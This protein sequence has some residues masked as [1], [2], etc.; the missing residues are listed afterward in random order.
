M[1]YL[2]E[3]AIFKIFKK[4]KNCRI[5]VTKYIVTVKTVIPL[6]NSIHRI[7]CFNNP[8][9]HS[10]LMENNLIYHNKDLQ[11]EL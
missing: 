1:K 7:K 6:F 10:F 8:Y 2:Q 5:Y 9:T 3:L 11:F 4:K